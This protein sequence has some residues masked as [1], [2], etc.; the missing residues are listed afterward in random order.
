MPKAKRLHSDEI[1]AVER[2][3]ES[4]WVAAVETGSDQV[5]LDGRHRVHA[6]YV[7]GRE[8]GPD[9]Y[10]LL[11]MSLGASTS[12]T[13]RT[14]ARREHLPLERI[15]VRLSH[16]SVHAMD[17]ADCDVR[18]VMIERVVCAIELIGPLKED[19]RRHLLEIAE[20]C[21]VHRTLAS[22]LDV[23]TVLGARAVSSAPA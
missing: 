7:D 13:L 5:L 4:G 12:T 2:S 22:K 18:T 6:D 11:L 3:L 8:G 1:A 15:I 10:E 21:P 17:C 20:M 23:Q 19:D 14:Y 16:G 9:P